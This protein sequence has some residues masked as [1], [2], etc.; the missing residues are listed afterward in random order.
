M[1]KRIQLWWSWSPGETVS[2]AVGPSVHPRGICR[3]PIQ[4]SAAMV[5]S[6]H[7]SSVNPQKPSP[8]C[9]VSWK[10]SVCCMLVTVSLS[11]SL[12]VSL[13]QVAQLDRF[14][15]YI[16]SACMHIYLRCLHLL[17]FPPICEA[18]SLM[19]FSRFGTS[20]QQLVTEP[21]QKNTC[22]DLLSTRC[23]DWCRPNCPQS[24]NTPQGGC[25]A[26]SRMRR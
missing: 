17:R 10:A 16:I 21:P 5:I 6:S 11:V 24:A 1:S 3:F 25:W 7:V 4:G 15:N 12:S 13:Q 2:V 20:R 18:R 22:S 26:T 23:T 19:L 14:G 9:G 8:R